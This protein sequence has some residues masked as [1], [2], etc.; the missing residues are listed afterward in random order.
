MSAP[1]AASGT[2]SVRQNVGRPREF[3][4]DKA[5]DRAMNV[6]WLKGYDGASLDDLLQ[7]MEIGRGSLYKAFGDKRSLYHATLRR[8]DA[9]VI[10]RSVAELRHGAG[11]G[12]AR[13]ARVLHGV[14]DAAEAGAER[15]GCFLCNASVDQAP[16]DP[17]VA[18]AVRAS[19]ERLDTGFCQAL[20][21]SPPLSRHQD[22]STLARQL[23]THYLGLRVLSKTGED[24]PRLR[25]LIES[26]IHGL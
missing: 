8:Y 20:A 13:I 6:F 18:A 25:A 15:K 4:L 7:A 2:A 23:T 19:I 10:G 17:D 5:V 21:E 3:D 9:E 26:I 24:V 16:H 14:A 1:H 22:R 11:D 12:K